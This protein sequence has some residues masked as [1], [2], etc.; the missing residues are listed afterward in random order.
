MGIGSKGRVCMT[1]IRLLPCTVATQI[2]QILVSTSLTCIHGTGC[3]LSDY[4]CQLLPSSSEV[5]SGAANV[6]S[7][8][9]TVRCLGTTISI[10]R[11]LTNWNCEK[12][13]PNPSYIIPT[14]L[15]AEAPVTKDRK[16]PGCRSLPC[17]MCSIWWGADLEATHCLIVPP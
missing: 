10:S 11:K 6:W 5:R 9:H 17:C 16:R 1:P 8:R 4:C 12:W 15:W 7:K 14:W 13:T 2:V 3:K